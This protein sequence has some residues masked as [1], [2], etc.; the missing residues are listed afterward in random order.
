MIRF[1]VQLE[2]IPQVIGAKETQNRSSVEIVLML[3]GLL[4]FRLN[5]KL[6]VKPDLFGIIHRHMEKSGHLLLLSFHVRVKQRLIPFPAAPKDIIFSA[7][8]LS[9]CDGVFHLGGRTGKH[10]GIRVRRRAVC[11]ARMTKKICG[12]PQEF[13]SRVLLQIFGLFNHGFKVLA[14]FRK[15]FPLGG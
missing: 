12:S 15:C 4:R 8:L 3:G 6:P 11:I 5:E 14:G 13:N 1:D 2:I 7:K 10:V 9:R